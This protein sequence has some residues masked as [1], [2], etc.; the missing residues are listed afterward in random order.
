MS[1][2]TSFSL[3]AQQHKSDT[4]VNNTTNLYFPAATQEVR[5]IYPDKKS[6]TAFTNATHPEPT[7][8]TGPSN[9]QYTSR[10]ISQTETNNPYD[11]V[12]VVRTIDNKTE[13]MYLAIINAFATILKDD[14]KTL[15]TNLLDMS[16]K[17]IVKAE[18][19]INIVSLLC[20]VST[21]KI[22][23]NYLDEDVSCIHK[24]N[25]IKKI[26]SIKV[27][28]KDMYIQY[29]TEY[30]KISNDFSISTSKVVVPKVD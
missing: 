25:P 4:N 18:A 7:T 1:K 22:I 11:S 28:N 20:D 30:N 16:G 24:F 26:A 2:L 19:L 8:N 14:N 6:D 29:N 27:D 15:L 3:T 12:T 9:V 10:D 21:D 13:Q 5:A 23:I 17:I